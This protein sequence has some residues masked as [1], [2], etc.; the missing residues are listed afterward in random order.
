MKKLIS[1]LNHKLR[2]NLVKY[3]FRFFVRYRYYIIPALLFAIAVFA[4]S[5]L[6]KIP[7]INTYLQQDLSN[8][9]LWLQNIVVGSLPLLLFVGASLYLWMDYTQHNKSLNS[10]NFSPVVKYSFI[11]HL[12]VVIFPLLRYKWKSLTYAT[13][14]SLLVILAS[15]GTI[16]SQISN[17]EAATTVAVTINQKTGS[18]D[19]NPSYTSVF[20]VTFSEAINNLSFIGSDI[21]LSGTAAGQTV[22]SISETTPFDSTTF[23]VRISA[24]S[25]GTITPSISADQVISLSNPSDTNQ[26]STSSDNSVTYNGQYQSDEFIT[27][28]KTD[29]PGGSDDNSITIPTYAG[30]GGTYDY[31][32][33]WDNDGVFEE[34]NLTTNTTHDF[35]SP[36]TYTIRIKGLFPS[37]H[38]ALGSDYEKILEV[39]QWGSNSWTTFNGAF[40]NASNLEIVALDA[41]NLNSVSSMN[42]TFFGAD[43]LN[44]NLGFWD[45]SN[46]SV[47]SRTFR[48]TDNFNGSLYNWDTS[49][50]TTM[51]GM[52]DSA[53]SFNQP[54]SNWDVS[55]VED[56]SYM[57]D[58]AAAFNQSLND[59]TT[60]NLDNLFATFQG[61]TSFNQPLSNWDVDS[62]TDM[63]GTFA[64]GPSMQSD[65]NQSL[66]DWDV[67]SVVHMETMFTGASSFNQPLDE[68]DTSSVTRMDSMFGLATSFNQPLNS[69]DTSNVTNMTSMFLGANNFNQPLN[70]WDT[71]S[72]TNMSN[73]FISYPGYPTTSDEPER[74]DF[75]QD[76]SDWDV[77]SVTTMDNIFA[78][79]SHT[80]QQIDTMITSWA[81]QAVQSG[82][83]LAGVFSICDAQDAIDDLVDNHSWIVDITSST[84]FGNY[85][86]ETDLSVDINSSK[87]RPIAS[88][89]SISYDITITNNGPN[90]YRYSNWNDLYVLLPGSFDIQNISSDDITIY[91][92]NNIAEAGPIVS[93][94][95][96]A[97]PMALYDITSIA[98]NG[99]NHNKKLLRVSMLSSGNL[100]SLAS[101]SSH[102]I[103]VSGEATASYSNPTIKAIFIPIR[104]PHFSDLVDIDFIIEEDDSDIT[105]QVFN[106]MNSNDLFT[107][108]I[109]LGTTFNNVSSSLVTDYFDPVFNFSGNNNKA[110]QHVLGSTTT[111]P[112]PTD[113]PGDENDPEEPTEETEAPTPTTG[114]PTT[115]TPTENQ[116]STGIEENETPLIAPESPGG[117]V[118]Q[119]Q[120]NDDS[121]PKPFLDTAGQLIS[122]LLILILFLLSLAYGWRAYKQYSSNK[123]LTG[124]IN[125]LKVTKEATDTYLKVVLH[126]LNTPVAIIGGAIELLESQKKIAV[127]TADY[128]KRNLNQYKQDVSNLSLDAQLAITDNSSGQPAPLLSVANK[129]K[130]FFLG[131]VSAIPKS[132][133]SL[134]N[135]AVFAPILVVF[136]SLSLVIALYTNGQLLNVDIIQQS[137]QIL[138]LLL[139]SLIIATSYKQRE[140]LAVARDIQQQA[141]YSEQKLIQQRNAFIEKASS[142]LSNNY[143]NLKVASN[144]LQTMPESKTLF[145]GLAMLSDTTTS[146]GSV[147]KLT[148]LSLDLPSLN[149]SQQIPQITEHYRERA[150]SKQVNI[151]LDIANNSILNIQPE[152]L[153]QIIGSTLNNAIQFSPERSTITVKTK[154]TAKNI[155]LSISDQGPGIPKD[156][157][158][159]LFQPFTKTTD[160]E[161]YNQ[162]GLGLSLYVNKLVVNQLGG[163]IQ[164]KNNKPNGTIVRMKLP[165]QKLTD[166]GAP[167][168][169]AP[170]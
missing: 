148:H 170:Q 39:N 73:M 37:I 52:F 42:E 100:A 143:E 154:S 82:V 68:W 89:T 126:H 16:S 95:D 168:I 88:G 18:A 167:I 98:N 44:N 109:G 120:D 7:A 99:P 13:A 133:S 157:L 4:T 50:V 86:G 72:V 19:P 141:L 74:M 35:G 2:F 113:E 59:W 125:K 58:E 34:T 92:I 106:L 60:T 56:M 164:V 46:V 162:Q 124:A 140:I 85:C 24:S 129:D 104:G 62:V 21:T 163:D 131:L 1:K 20:T 49:S 137:L 53:T 57:F 36:G 3:R 103:S 139:I 111:D 17:V 138:C 147:T 14:S 9:N 29:N 127:N 117:E 28:W 135:P 160:V 114:S 101:G 116:P 149:L 152:Q 122:W 128:I 38:T 30:Y 130:G 121:T 151:K 26:A 5:A 70:E 153:N 97:T 40:Q 136:V 48:D 75:S 71:S 84:V 47:M 108:G 55:A 90:K 69:W 27:T 105:S 32:V 31:D 76:L 54:L 107:S 93:S 45:T 112:D 43:S 25:S 63:R 155:H 115:N 77:T 65:F 158:D 166:G 145:N 79:T 159:Q 61:A 81:G 22:E 83:R 12:S 15:L 161:T 96:H 144:K 80:P 110:F 102:K 78:L 33:D 169:I 119:F 23:E 146:L 51:T 87:K 118:Y 165:K 41:P 132:G 10:S 91:T 66:N 150:T 8:Y 64:S 134:K 123:M 94:H 11:H 6:L 156:K 67:S 142:V